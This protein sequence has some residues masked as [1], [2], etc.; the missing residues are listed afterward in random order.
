M[1][2]TRTLLGLAAAAGTA[3]PLVAQYPPQVRPN[4][5]VYPAPPWITNAPRSG[6]L[7]A[8]LPA[9]PD[10]PPAPAADRPPQVTEVR[11]GPA[12][13]QAEAA[14]APGSAA[15][16][17]AATPPPAAP[18]AVVTPVGFVTPAAPPAGRPAPSAGPRLYAPVAPTPDVWKSAAPRAL[19]GTTGPGVAPPR[20]AP[21]TP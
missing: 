9:L 19:P 6:A 5:I 7:P 12:A 18:A 17:P 20:A 4:T 21:K 13:P 8:Q 16:R 11:T 3:A 2:L 1:P 10:A 15:A 14:R